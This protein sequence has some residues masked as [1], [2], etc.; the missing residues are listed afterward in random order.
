LTWHMVHPKSAINIQNLD[1]QAIFL[2]LIYLF[3]RGL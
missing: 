3:S 2:L 1:T